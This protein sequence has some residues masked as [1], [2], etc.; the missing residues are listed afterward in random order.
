MD[1]LGLFFYVRLYLIS[2]M[3]FVM[4]CSPTKFTPVV[5][6]DALCKGEQSVGDA[7]CVVVDGVTYKTETFYI[8]GGKS[9][10][11]ILNDNSAS[12]L[13]TQ[14]KL[15]LKFRGFIDSLKMSQVDYRVGVAT[16]DLNTKGLVKM[17]DG[18]RYIS[19]STVNA[20][21]E[22]NRAIIREETLR[23]ENV[24]VSYFCLLKDAQGNC[25]NYDFQ[26]SEGYARD[27]A[28]NCV[29]QDERGLLKGAEIISKNEGSFIRDDAHL[30]VVVISNEDARSGLYKTDN[31]Y[32]L[33]SEE[34]AEGFTNLISSVYP[35]KYWEFYS[36]IAQSSECIGEQV[37]SLKDPRGNVVRDSS[38]RSVINANRGE[39]YAS[40][41]ES[42]S[43]NADGQPS[44]R[45]QVLSL[46]DAD[47]AQHFKTIAQKISESARRMTL[48]CTP[49]ETPQVS[50][51]RSASKSTS[52][53]GSGPSSS[54]SSLAQS[55]SI[56]NQ[57][58]TAA[59]STTQAP[60]FNWTPG[61][62]FI[63]FNKGS[64]RQLISVSYKCFAGSVQ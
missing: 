20:E 49:L 37:R 1:Q 61:S 36:I 53:N 15:G 48:P 35:N 2:V 28:P 18:S 47:Y 31:R 40:I 27:Y 54:L 5:S 14:R 42:A 12:M 46:C 64:E 21:S 17:S 4:S 39:V 52:S 19:P 33:A 45:G 41:S 7:S 11:L 26:Q 23:C 16:F 60:S 30:T 6:N 24:I 44:R 43:I 50:F 10:I 63:T 34:T 22:F 51:V 3:M 57:S 8:G 38:G 25:M 59:Q 56:Q 13:E 58:T 55:V 32:A 29:A 62:S 9:D